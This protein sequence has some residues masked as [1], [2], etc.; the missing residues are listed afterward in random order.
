MS[1][2]ELINGDIVRKL[3]KLFESK[4]NNSKKEDK[5]PKEPPIARRAEDFPF[6]IAQ[7]GLTSTLTFFLSKVGKESDDLL[8]K[9][10][11]YFSGIVDKPG[12]DVKDDAT[13]PDV[14]KGYASYL[15]LVLVWPLG[16]ALKEVGIDISSQSN[17]VD[18]V[19]NKLDAIKQ[20]EMKLELRIMPSL[21]ELKKIIKALS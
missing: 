19:L 1:S 7:Y 3:V 8:K 15:A 17:I 6:M 20:N 10:F 21:L 5:E 11:D 18:Q 2:G 16:K 9:G 4:T 13:N 14:G 12:G